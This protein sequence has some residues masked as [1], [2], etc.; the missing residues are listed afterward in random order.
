MQ[1]L[2]TISRVKQRQKY[3]E[4]GSVHNHTTMRGIESEKYGRSYAIV[5]AQLK[6]HTHTPV[7]TR[8]VRAMSNSQMFLQM[9]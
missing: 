9:L 7:D 3:W 2:K 4:S 8:I 5:S 1:S 6:K